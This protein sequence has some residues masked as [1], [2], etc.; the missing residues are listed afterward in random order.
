MK[1]VY[2]FRL[3]EHSPG[4]ERKLRHKNGDNLQALVMKHKSYFIAIIASAL[5]FIFR[6]LLFDIAFV[7]GNSMYPTLG[8]NDILFVNHFQ[9]TPSHND[10]VLIHIPTETT[11]DEVIVKRIIAI[12]GETVEIDYENNAVYV[13]GSRLI[14]PYINSECDDPMIK[15]EENHT[16]LVPEGY[17]FVLG[18]N[19]NHSTD[20]RS[21]VIGMIH[22]SQIIGKVEFWVPLSR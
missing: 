19:R 8:S 17:V 20:S 9:Y 14:E 21:S 12:G 11:R 3:W 15:K 7:K 22:I 6:I 18:D 16:F 10:I 5:L 4:N 1:R 2:R 13:D